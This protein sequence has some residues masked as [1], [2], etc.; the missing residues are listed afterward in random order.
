MDHRFGHQ[1]AYYL[2][3]FLRCP[4]S[5]EQVRNMDIRFVS[6]IIKVMVE[7]IGKLQTKRVLPYPFY[8]FINV[9]WSRPSVL[10][11]GSLIESVVLHHFK[12]GS[13]IH[14]FL[15]PCFFKKRDRTLPVLFGIRLFTDDFRNL[16]HCPQVICRFHLLVGRTHGQPLHFLL[17]TSV[18][19]TE[20]KVGNSFP[21]SVQQKNYGMFRTYCRGRLES[22]GPVFL[23]RC[24]QMNQGSR[25]IPHLRRFGQYQQRKFSAEGIP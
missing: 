16:C 12:S 8:H 3:G 20:I 25:H 14:K 22:G 10:P 24:I 11:T 5:V 18:S 1:T 7:E 13:H 6:L 17:H 21:V 4:K 23:S 9:L 2:L 19:F 15:L